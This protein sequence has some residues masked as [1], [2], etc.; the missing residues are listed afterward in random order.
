MLI[1]LQTPSV[2]SPRLIVHVD[3]SVVKGDPSVYTEDERGNRELL[4]I[5][6]YTH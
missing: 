6:F 2:L 1:R 5:K 3:V 4:D